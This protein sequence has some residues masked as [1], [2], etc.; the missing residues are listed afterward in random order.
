MNQ[1]QK[2]R[3]LVAALV[4]SGMF[5]ASLA[6]DYV[7][8]LDDKIYEGLCRVFKIENNAT[9][10]V[11]NEELDFIILVGADDTCPTCVK[12]NAQNCL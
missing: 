4:V 11:K 8:K 9:Q 12:Q 2:S 6:R 10:S 1:S 3:L 7:S 5:G